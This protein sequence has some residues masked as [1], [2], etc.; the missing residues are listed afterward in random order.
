LGRVRRLTAALVIAGVAVAVSAAT[1]LA[2]QAAAPTACTINSVHVLTP[3]WNVSCTRPTRVS[4]EVVYDAMDNAFP[5]SPIH[6][7][8]TYHQRVSPGIP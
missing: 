1:A 8:T 3:S 5:P 2:A 7:D 4:I 6:D